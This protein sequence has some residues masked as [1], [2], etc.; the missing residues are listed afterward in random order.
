MELFFRSL[1]TRDAGAV[2][3]RESLAERIAYG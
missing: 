2:D 3:L 1:Q